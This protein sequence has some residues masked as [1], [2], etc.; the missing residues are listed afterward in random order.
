MQIYV[1]NKQFEIIQLIDRYVSFIWTDRYNS[2]GDFELYM[3]DNEQ[4]CEYIKPNNYIYVKNNKNEYMIIE[5]IKTEYHD[6]SQ[7]IVVTGR[8]LASILDRRVVLGLRYINNFEEDE[9][10]PRLNLGQV[11]KTIIDENIIHP[12]NSDIGTNENANQYLKS[13]WT[14]NKTNRKISNFIFDEITDANDPNHRIRTI[15]PKN[16]QYQG[17]NI[18]SLVEELC[19]KYYIGFR[20][21]YDNGSFHLYLYDGLFRTSDQSSNDVVI[22][23]P[24]YDTLYNMV[25][26]ENGAAIKNVIIGAGNDSNDELDRVYGVTDVNGNNLLAISSAYS[27]LDLRETYVTCESVK[28]ELTDD[29]GNTIEESGDEDDNYRKRI[30]RKASEALAKN[31]K[32][33]QTFEGDIDTTIMYQLGEDYDIGDVCEL[34][35]WYKQNKKIRVTEVIKCQDSSG[36]KMYPSLEIYTEVQDEEE[37]QY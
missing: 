29:Y 17:E 37:V 24:F 2:A 35:D 3:P 8:S 5:N 12:E 23:S 18:Y 19:K 25:S 14:Y 11:I 32:A 7:Y 21:Y 28:R 13:Y 16:L 22:F 4:T 1:L 31:N 9:T 36:Y 27:G 30:N 26:V 20:V 6:S 15:V 34:Q 10:T 33:S